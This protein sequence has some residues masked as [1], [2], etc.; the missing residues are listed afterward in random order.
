M[1]VRYGLKLI[2]RLTDLAEAFTSLSLFAFHGNGST[3]TIILP[4]KQKFTFRCAPPTNR[5]FNLS[6]NSQISFP[7]TLLIEVDEVVR[8]Y[9]A[10]YPPEIDTQNRII[11]LNKRNY[12]PIGFIRFG[13]CAGEQYAYISIGA[14][15]FSQNR[16][17]QYSA[18]VHHQFT[19]IVKSTNGMAGLI[20]CN[21]GEM[22]AFTEDFK[23]V[24]VVV[25]EEDDDDID[26]QVAQILSQ[27]EGGL[28]PPSFG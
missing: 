17:F 8:E 20:D 19:E 21:N 10:A 23:A 24:N 27:I 26:K 16:L 5:K 12:Y 18:S 11:Q 25:A 4:N 28:Q 1:G 15:S 9:I 13:L 3:A 6:V 22:V 2:Y 14:V 7:T